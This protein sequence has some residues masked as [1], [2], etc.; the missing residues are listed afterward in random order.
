MDVELTSCSNK[1]HIKLEEPPS[2]Y[3]SDSSGIDHN[4]GCNDRPKLTRAQSIKQSI[5]KNTLDFFGVASENEEV[6]EKWDQRRLRLRSRLGKIKSS[7]SGSFYGDETDGMHFSAVVQYAMAQNS[8]VKRRRENAAKLLWR[9]ASKKLLDK[10]QY[11]A[12]TIDSFRGRSYALADLNDDDIS[13]FSS[14]SHLEYPSI[15]PSS[16]L[17]TPSFIDDHFFFFDEPIIDEELELDQADGGPS[18]MPTPK[19]EHRVESSSQ[20]RSMSR[21]VSER[22]NRIERPIERKKKK[23]EFGKSVVANILN[24][25]LLRNRIT[26]SVREQIDEFS[27]HRPYFTYWLSFVQVVVLIVMISVY[28]FAPIGVSER[29]TQKNILVSRNGV[30]GMELKGKKEVESFW[31]G[32]TLQTLIIL[33][34]KYAPCMRHDIQLYRELL[35][36]RAMENNTGCCIQT[37]NTGCIQRS[38]RECSSSFTTYKP[39]TVC[40]QDPKA[41]LTPPSKPPNEWGKLAI[42]EWPVCQKS[43]NISQLPREDYPHMHCEIT[44][45][46]CCIGTQAECIITN[47]DYCDFKDGIYHADKT[48]CSQVDCL[49]STCG[50]LPFVKQDQPD[51]IYRLWL[52]LFLHAGILHLVIVL[53]FNFTILQDIELMAGW[54]RT[55]LIY[56]LSGIGGSL[57]S[58]ILLPYSPEVG[59]SGSC[60]GII[61]CLFVE[62]IQS[63]QLYKTPWIGFFKLCGLVLVLFLIGLLPYIDNFAHIF[64]FVYGFLLSIIFLPY[65]TFGDWDRRR[66][67]IQ[68]AVAIVILFIITTVGFILFYKVQEFHSAAITFFNCI[69]I[70][71][72]FC[73]NYHQGQSLESRGDF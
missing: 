28:P 20:A 61:A 36:E 16:G 24:L 7:Q 8:I 25:S 19:I 55:A 39:S 15:T 58:S 72:N 40:G 26:S 9:S 5:T 54:L 44:G 3:V 60:F 12:S 62:Y 47:K 45:R 32:P 70:T 53:I 31:I 52:S 51:Q 71:D 18:A 63:W 59:P 43:T 27:D 2:I 4:N 50:L 38:K 41:C 42:T 13:V 37:H 14:A 46:P 64:G 6:R 29:S 34:A 68:I 33:G 1:N 30:L 49:A 11:A 66:K 23:R 57:W 21:Q 56:L 65:I 48:L 67:K 73:K 17:P 10:P 22:R 69:P 35:Y